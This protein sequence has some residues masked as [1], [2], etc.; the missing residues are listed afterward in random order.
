M[1]MPCHGILSNFTHLGL[2]ICLCMGITL[3]KFLNSLFDIP[4]TVLVV[5]V[6]MIMPKDERLKQRNH[7][8]LGQ[9]LVKAQAGLLF[10]SI[11]KVKIPASTACLTNALLHALFCF[12]HVDLGTVLLITTLKLSCTKH[13]G[14]AMA[15][16]DMGR[17][18]RP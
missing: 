6:S 1:K 12:F 8:G 10:L 4:S 15:Q 17:K 7:L 14:S 16:S 18:L 13:Q 11:W 2:S 9:C 5:N 3:P